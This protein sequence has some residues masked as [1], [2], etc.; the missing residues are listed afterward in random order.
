M[1]VGMTKPDARR[2][3][4]PARETP[5]LEWAAGATGLA[6]FLSVIG[7]TVLNGL[8]QDRPPSI[9]VEIEDIAQQGGAYTVSFDVINAGDKTASAVRLTANLSVEGKPGQERDVE[10]DFL[11]PHSRRKAAVIFSS[12]PKQGRLEIQ[13]Q[14]YRRP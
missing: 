9:Q 12:D 4:A 5:L 1:E 3:K 8:H 10:I 6:L 13:A 2:S 11:P 14:S 7:L